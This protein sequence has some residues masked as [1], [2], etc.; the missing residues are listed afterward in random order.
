MP[1]RSMV[2]RC[3]KNSLALGVLR[4]SV[5]WACVLHAQSGPLQDSFPHEQRFITVA[6]GVKLE[7]VDWGGTGRA[8]ILLAG[9]D[10]DAHVLDAF[11]SP[12]A[13]TY[14]VYGITRRGVGH[15]AHQRLQMLTTGPIALVMMF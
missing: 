11:A 13:P 5:I 3:L 7:V 6:E 1:I 15:R 2:L 9:L 14:H 12:L 4:A 10:D 8:L